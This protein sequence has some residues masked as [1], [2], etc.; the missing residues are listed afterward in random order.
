[1]RDLSYKKYKHVVAA[2]CSYTHNSYE[3]AN[4]ERENRIPVEQ[5]V[6]GKLPSTSYVHELGKLADSESYNLAKNGLSFKF[7]LYYAFLWIQNNL[8]KVEESLLLV[9]LTHRRR[10]TFFNPKHQGKL[11]LK[12]LKGP[13]SVPYV[14]PTKH[15][16]V[17]EFKNQEWLQREVK[18]LG[19]TTDA[20]SNFTYILWNCLNDNNQRDV[21]DEMYMVMLQN[22]CNTIGLDILFIDM[23]NE[24]E[25]W[26]TFNLKDW[27]DI[28]YPV[29]KWPDGSGS[30]KH[31][32]TVKDETYNGEHP[33]YNDHVELAELLYE[34][35]KEN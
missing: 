22:Y 30:W 34:Y 1:M 2:G 13:L 25:R 8:D 10:E 16:P 26:P 23:T 35:I 4:P 28:V 19:V 24:A 33:N 14:V 20:Y 15:T 9:G 5:Y 29:F 6:N 11:R 3:N 31:Y 21:L 12:G 7:V 17:E 32:L 27:R 18:S